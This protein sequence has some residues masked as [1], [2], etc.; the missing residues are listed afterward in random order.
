MVFLSDLLSS[1]EAQTAPPSEHVFVDADS[2]DGTL[3]AIRDY[4]TRVAYPVRIIRDEGQGIA[5]AMNL[6]AFESNGSHLLF[7]HSDDRL[8]SNSSLTDMY[9]EMKP[10]SMWY[11]SNCLYIDAQGK[12]TGH[13]PKIPGTISDLVYKNFISHPSTVMRKDFF[14][15]CGEFDTRFKIAMDYDLWHRAVKKSEPQQSEKTLS[16]FRVHDAGTSSGSPLLL[17]QE[18]LRVKLENSTLPKQKSLALAN[19]GFEVLFIWFPK[20][21]PHVLR[22]LRRPI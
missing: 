15:E 21:R 18:T 2:T 4:E 16:H 5:Q 10:E 11:T 19:Y 22:L 14:H 20:I 9:N 7:L 17:S 1:I 12:T 8:S 13:A 3:V 6:G